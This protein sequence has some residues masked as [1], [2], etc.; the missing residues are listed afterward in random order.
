MT[1]EQK[2]WIDCAS[3]ETL[4]RRYRFSPVGDTMFVG[5]CG[6]YYTDIMNTKCYQCD[7]VAISKQ[8]GWG[9]L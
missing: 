8:I 5:D 2:S 9:S 1:S 7:H 4:L 3:Y 6:I